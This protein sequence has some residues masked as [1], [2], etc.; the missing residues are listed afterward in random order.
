MLLLFLTACGYPDINRDIIARTDVYGDGIHFGTDESFGRDT[1]VWISLVDVGN[2]YDWRRDVAFNA[3]DFTLTLLRNKTPV[4]S[5]KGGTRAQIGPEP[6]RHHILNG[7]LYTE[8]FNGV[9]TIIKKD[10]ILVA[11]VTGRQALKGIL[12]SVSPPYLLLKN[13]TDGSISL[14][15]GNSVIFSDDKGEICHGFGE[16]GAKDSGALFFRDTIPCFLYHNTVYSKLYVYLVS[17]KN[18]Q[19][20]NISEKAISFLDARLEGDDLEYLAKSYP[21]CLYFSKSKTTTDISLGGAYSWSKATI[22]EAGENPVVIGEYCLSDGSIH[23]G[24]YRNGQVVEMGP[25]DSRTMMSGEKFANVT[26]RSNGLVT[27][28][29][30]LSAT[31]D[32][33]CYNLSSGN[34]EFQGR[35]FMA[36]T[37]KEE[38]KGTFLWAN[39]ERLCEFP[40]NGY[41]S[42]INVSVV[43]HSK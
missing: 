39:G 23:S 21:G 27:V 1:T 20:F 28:S 26:H 22:A 2:G 25:E 10:G 14:R 35:L 38:G 41:I 9:E 5:L 30:D 29:G 37:P 4:L 34:V 15:R 12:G 13:V 32:E 17:G 6:D 40:V 16:D 24:Y 33:T 7:S 43:N 36:L 31:I 18:R 3:E 8:Y 42:S 19:E 11:T